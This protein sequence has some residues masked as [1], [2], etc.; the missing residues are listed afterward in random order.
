MKQT[1]MHDSPGTVVF[2]CRKSQRNSNGITLNGGAKWRW[3][4]LNAAEVA[5]NWRLSTRSVVN[6]ARSQ[7]Y[8]TLAVLQLILA[9]LQIDRQS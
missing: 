3:G 4:T 2:C 5:E 7:V 8:H 1:T 9:Q 6:L